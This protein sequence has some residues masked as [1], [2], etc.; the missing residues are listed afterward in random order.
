MT[1][2]GKRP[3]TSTWLA[4]AIP[5]CWRLFGVLRL[6]RR[7][8]GLLHRRQEQCNEKPLD[9]EDDQEFNDHEAAADAAGLREPKHY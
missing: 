2:T 3:W 7:L 1:W 9:R 6:P 5:I 4:S 8:A